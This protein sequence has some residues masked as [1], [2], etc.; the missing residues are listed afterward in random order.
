MVRPLT[1]PKF[2]YLTMHASNFDFIIDSMTRHLCF[3]SFVFFYNKTYSHFQL[4]ERIQ[5]IFVFINL[6]D[7]TDNQDTCHMYGL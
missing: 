4:R 5:G 1:V 6:Y 7:K 2:S 3:L